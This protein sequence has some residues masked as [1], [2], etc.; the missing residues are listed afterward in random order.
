MNRRG[1]CQFVAAIP[2]LGQ[3]LL[4]E[5]VVDSAATCKCCDACAEPASVSYTITSVNGDVCD[6]LASGVI[7]IEAG[8]DREK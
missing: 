7:W 1:F 3:L 2:F 8:N 4:G 6:V 5:S